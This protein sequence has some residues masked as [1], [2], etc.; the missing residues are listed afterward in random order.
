MFADQKIYE[1][2]GLLAA[3]YSLYQA[4]KLHE[5]EHE[6]AQRRHRE[7]IELAKKQHEKDMKTVKQTYLLQIFN[8]LEQHFQQLNADLIASSRESE[9]DMFDQRNQ[10]FQ[11]IILASSVMFSALSSVIVEGTLP[12]NATEFLLIAYSLTSALSF[13]F[14][15]LCIVFSMEL[16]MRTSL[17]MYR[18][19]NKHTRTLRSAIEDTKRMMK[20]LRGEASYLE[21]GNDLTSTQNLFSVG[22]VAGTAT[23]GL[24]SVTNRNRASAGNNSSTGSVRYTAPPKLRRAISKMDPDDVEEEWLRH[25]EEIR[26]YLKQRE[27]INDRTSID[28]GSHKRRSFKD[29]WIESCKFWWDLAILFFY[30]GSLNLLLAIMIF[31]WGQFLLSYNSLVG[32]IIAV[33]LIGLVL[34]TGISTVIVMRHQ[35][36]S[37]NMNNIARTASDIEAM[38]AAG[39]LTDNVSRAGAGALDARRLHSTPFN[40]LYHQH[41]YTSRHHLQHHQDQQQSQGSYGMQLDLKREGAAVGPRSPSDTF[42]DEEEKRP[43]S[44]VSVDRGLRNGTGG[45]GGGVVGSN[46]AFLAADMSPATL[47][48]SSTASGSNSSSSSS[49]RYYHSINPHRIPQQQ[50]QQQQQQSS[51]FAQIRSSPHYEQQQYPQ[52]AY[53]T[54]VDNASNMPQQSKHNYQEPEQ[55]QHHVYDQ[56]PQQHNPSTLSETSLQQLQQLHSGAPSTSSG[57]GHAA[58][59]R[60]SLD[61]DTD[62][63]SSI[64]ASSSRTVSAGNQT[65]DPYGA[66]LGYRH[67]QRHRSHSQ[68]QQQSQQRRMFRAPASLSP[69]RLFRRT[70]SRS[71]HGSNPSREGTPTGRSTHSGFSAFSAHTA[72]SRPHGAGAGAGSGAWDRSGIASDVG[73][74]HAEGGGG[75]V[76]MGMV[77]IEEG[78]VGVAGGENPN[79]ATAEPDSYSS[80]PQEGGIWI[81]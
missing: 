48:L 35:T 5:T 18:R 26:G 19:A 24:D 10:S 76:Q 32:A 8:S 66:S 30:A 63:H 27:E 41:N 11:T 73:R 9:R 77:T 43:D 54:P 31:M 59:L 70:S 13:A 72:Y 46:S 53:H 64:T 14:L 2:G 21:R 60:L 25:E 38:A 79:D 78:R 75:G 44:A 1:Y 65:D 56:P 16:V 45:E 49:S 50:Q 7:A 33:S 81:V 3:G 57:A 42:R 39:L 67:R 80:D 29:F 55:Q 12:T 17:F 69:G 34:V 20:R 37:R 74:G 58:P 71:N 52:R 36:L 22:A 40:H 6:R 28:L 47:P 62:A 51:M 61:G 23:G 68:Q 15:F 4:Q